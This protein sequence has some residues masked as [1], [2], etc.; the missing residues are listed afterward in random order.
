MNIATI[1]QFEYF[2]NVDL[3][4]ARA[5]AAGV[6]GEAYEHYQTTSKGPKKGRFNGRVTIRYKPLNNGDLYAF[7]KA[8]HRQ[9]VADAVAAGLCVSAAVLADYP[10]LQ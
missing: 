4:T 1:T 9:A 3:V 2:E 10:D 6:K 5:I 8:D 7:G